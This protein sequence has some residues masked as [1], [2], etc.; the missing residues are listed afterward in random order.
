M[1]A[2][3]GWRSGPGVA[4]AM[5][6]SAVLAAGAGWP[7]PLTAQRAPLMVERLAAL[8]SLI[9]TAPAA[10]VWSPD[11]TRL[12]FLWNDQAMPFHDVW[13]VDAAGGPPRKLTDLKGGPRRPASPAAQPIQDDFQEL[14]SD[15]AD[16]LRPGAAEAVW[17]P[18]GNSLIV[19]CEDRLYR[20]NADGGGSTR[21]ELPPAVRTALSFSP[22]GRFL[23]WI[24][25]GDLWLWNQETN[26]VSQVT[27][28][29]VPPIGSIPG[30]AYTHP[31]AEFTLPKWSPDSRA[32]AMHWDDRRRV[33]KLLFP[34]YLGEHVRITELR[35]DL[36]G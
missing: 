31:D 33:R 30:S 11:A 27:H 17:T 23:S 10:P 7:A 35:R 12:A 5:A 3:V 2:W 24:Q 34:D 21:L 4:V 14:T 6:A 26:A 25:D 13:V 20:V 32:V 15:A 36:P 19:S 22:N 1:T 18:D 28:A 8:P 16:R 9:G 29:G